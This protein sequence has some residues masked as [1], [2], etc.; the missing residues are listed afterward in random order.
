MTLSCFSCFFF[1][2]LL[3]VIDFQNKSRVIMTVFHS[4]NKLLSV[5]HAIRNWR[6]KEEKDSGLS[7]RVA[8]R[9][10]RLRQREEKIAL[11][12]NYHSPISSAYPYVI[13]AL[14][15][16]LTKERFCLWRREC[17]FFSYFALICHGFVIIAV[18]SLHKRKN[19]TT[20]INLW[21]HT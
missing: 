16:F 15:C 14:N 5:K 2:K 7:F 18:C 19:K 6:Y 10:E 3:A 4:I 20:K 12:F 13:V 1:F 21:S 9:A 17:H 8:T 11:Q